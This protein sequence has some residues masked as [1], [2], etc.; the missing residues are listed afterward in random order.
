MTE[1]LLDK[2]RKLYTVKVYIPEDLVMYY[3]LA[4]QLNSVNLPTLAQAFEEF[5]NEKYP[6]LCKV[7]G[8]C[9]FFRNG[10]IPFEVEVNWQ[11][12][13]LWDSLSC[14]QKDCAILQFNDWLKSKTFGG[15]G[16]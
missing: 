8:S 7:D 2:Y 6:S 5:L 9:L 16:V 3:L 10:L 11:T 14:N 15:K 1:T 13:E 12:K 4:P